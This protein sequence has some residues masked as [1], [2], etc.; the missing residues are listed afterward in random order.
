M[1]GFL[2]VLRSSST[3]QLPP[4][5]LFRSATTSTS[6]VKAVESIRKSSMSPR[7]SAPTYCQRVRFVVIFYF[8]FT[9]V[10]IKRAYTSR[11]NIPNPLDYY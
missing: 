7:P 10:G 2:E 9:N 8:F 1:I 5:D 6:R 4:L 3:R 11:V